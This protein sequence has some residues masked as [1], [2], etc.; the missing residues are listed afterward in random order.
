M[1]IQKRE[2]EYAKEVDDV[3]VL[4]VKIVEMAKA[5]MSVVEIG[6]GAVTPLIDAVANIQG[7]GEEIAANK[8][9]AISTIGYRVGE[10]AGALLG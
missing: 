3:A 2:V 6:A 7:V 9:V 1:A 5:G 8:K 10:I 4:L